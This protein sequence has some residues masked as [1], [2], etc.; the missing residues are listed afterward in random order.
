MHNNNNNNNNNS[1]N[2]NNNNEDLFDS[3]I[4]TMALRT[5]NYKNKHKCSNITI[6]DCKYYKH[7]N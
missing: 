2:N 4:F 3:Y 5:Q 6:Y 7:D 1:N